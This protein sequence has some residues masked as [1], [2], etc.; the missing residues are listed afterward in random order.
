MSVILRE[1]RRV[2]ETGPAPSDVV[3]TYDHNQVSHDLVFRA[4]GGT[5]YKIVWGD[6]A[7]ET[8]TASG[9]D[10]TVSHTYGGAGTY[11]VNIEKFTN[12]DISR[13]ILN[14]KGVQYIDLS[15][16]TNLENI[17]LP[18]NGSMTS[19]TWPTAQANAGYKWIDVSQSGLVN[20]D[21]VGV[22]DGCWV[23]FFQCPNL[24]TAPLTNLTGE[25]YR[26][27]FYGNPELTTKITLN[28]GI[29]FGNSNANFVFCDS[30]PKFEGISFENT[31]GN[32]TAINCN[33]CN[34]TGN[35][36]FG[37]LNLVG[38]D[39][40]SYRNP[41]LTGYVFTNCTGT[42]YRIRSW[43]CILSEID[44]TGANINLSNNAYMDLTRNYVLTAIRL[45][46]DSTGV[47]ETLNLTECGTVTQANQFGATTIDPNA[48]FILENMGITDVQLDDWYNQA[49]PVAAAAGAT[50]SFSSINGI[51]ATAGSLAARNA[52]IAAG[53][54]V[55]IV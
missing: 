14:N 13:I 43:D 21:P 10:D 15:N 12:D 4:S 1:Y 3:I 36:N 26:L 40:K 18:N 32:L 50:G 48:T 17:D 47:W 27:Y 22:M 35:L 39:V 20:F 5:D 6:G 16:A 29:F 9:G 11:T 46:A 19:I 44:L 49:Q 42:L 34:F 24:V 23:R 41:L 7:E 37:N 30:S 55:N 52:L 33:D 31:T 38:A 25:L 2:V 28:A 54:T 45:R 53:Y 51:V 8:V